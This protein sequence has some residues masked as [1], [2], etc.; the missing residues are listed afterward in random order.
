MNPS[1]VTSQVLIDGARNFVIRLTG[2]QDGTGTQLNYL[3][4]IDV[5]TMNPP[6]GPSFKIRR[7]Q[8]KVLGGIVQLAWETSELPANPRT[9]AELQLTGD[10]RDYRFGGMSTRGIPNATGS[11]LLSTLGF[12]VG[13]SFDL[14]FEC[15][16]GVGTQFG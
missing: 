6:A 9:F 8:F 4:V 10:E 2:V 7:L 3:K 16:K 14:T 1:A 5:D 12:D 15:I 11:V 13:S